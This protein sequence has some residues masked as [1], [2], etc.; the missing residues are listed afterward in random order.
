MAGRYEDRFRNWHPVHERNGE[1]FCGNV[2]V[3]AS[4]AATESGLSLPPPVRDAL[5]LTDHARLHRCSECN[6]GFIAHHAARFCTP[7]CGSAA[8]GRVQKKTLE[9]RSTACHAFWREQIEEE[10]R[11]CGKMILG[12]PRL[13]RRFCSVACKQAAYRKALKIAKQT[14]SA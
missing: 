6:A 14:P 1:L 4:A 10:C 12:A 7:E 5:N 3:H 11:N 8:R 9:K 2:R 13:P